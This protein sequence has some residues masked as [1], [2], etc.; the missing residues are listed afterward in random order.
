[1]AT[2]LSWPLTMTLMR[3]PE[4]PGG[5]LGLDS[6]GHEPAI[7]QH[8]EMRRMC[9]TKTGSAYAGTRWPSPWRSQPQPSLAILSRCEPRRVGRQPAARRVVVLPPCSHFLPVGVLRLLREG[10]SRG[11]L[12]P[13]LPP[14]RL[15]L[16]AGTLSPAAAR[17]RR[18]DLQDCQ[19]PE[20]TQRLCPP[21]SPARPGGIFLPAGRC[22]DRSA[23][24]PACMIRRIIASG[25]GVLSPSTCTRR[26]NSSRNSSICTT[27]L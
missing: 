2:S 11:S 1:M 20:A 22:F 21:R 4:G 9:S 24:L 8:N 13:R 7:Q 15:G 26:R 23:C 5:K 14:H 17:T 6:S 3:V 10:R 12:Q 18:A 25:S 27:T 16:D 19:R